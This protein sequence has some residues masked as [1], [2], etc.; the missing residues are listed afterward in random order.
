MHIKVEDKNNIA[1]YVNKK[2]ERDSIT[3]MPEAHSEPS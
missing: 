3:R 1:H 2:L